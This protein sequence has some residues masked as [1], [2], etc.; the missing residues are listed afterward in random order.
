MIRSGALQVMRTEYVLAARAA[1][2]KHRSRSRVRHV[3]P[4]VTSLI[5]VQ[6][7]VSFAIA[8]LAEAALSFLGYGTPPPTPSWGRMLQ[9]S[10]EFLFSAPRLAVFPGIAI[11]DR[12]AGLQPARRRSP[13]PLRSETG[14]RA[15]TSDVLTVQGLPSPCD[16]TSL[17]VGRRS[18]GRAGGAGRVD[19]G[20]RFGQV[21]DRVE[22]PRSAAGR[23]ARDR[24]G[25]PQPASTTT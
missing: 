24:I 7:S 19:R 3:L 21:A 14:G 4:N 20:V 5:T 13:G 2:R 18:D 11:A 8:V 16:D 6:A 25:T 22:H 9:E 10:Q 1:G 17:V 23:R 12:R 15:M